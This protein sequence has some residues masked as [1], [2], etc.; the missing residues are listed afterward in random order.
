M[1]E[2]YKDK[3]T[4]SIRPQLFSNDSEQLAKALAKEKSNKR[5]QIRKFYDEVVRL[6]LLAKANPSEWDNVL[7][8]VHMLVA[9]AAYA[10]GRSLVTPDFVEFMKGSVNQIELGRD[11]DVFANFFEA[12]MG[13]YRKYRPRDN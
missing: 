7:P 2:F 11:L 8:Y 3:A 10:E 13:F 12:F 6:N 5:S 4:R 1:I 9:K